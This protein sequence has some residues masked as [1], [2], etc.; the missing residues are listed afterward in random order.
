[1]TTH[2]KWGNPVSAPAG[3]VRG[4]ERA[5]ELF[6]SYQAD[7]VVEIDAML[8]EYPDFALGHA[9]RAGLM[10]TTSD[11][12]FD[13]ELRRS[14]SAAE[15]LA[16]RANERERGH[17][18]AARAWADGEFDRAIELW[19]RVAVAHP[20]DL[21]ATQ[22][23][24][25]GDFYLGYS[26]MLRDRVARV[27][28]HWSR[29]DSGY[30]YLLGMHAFGL[31]ESGDYRR[32]EATGRAAI[33]LD[34]KDAWAVHA[35]AHVLEMQGRAD[36][37]AAFLEDS[38]Q[39]W[40]P[41]CLMSFHN[42][43][44]LTLFNLDRGH[45]AKALQIY[46]DKVAAGGFAQALELVDGSG[47]LWRL[48]ALGHDVGARWQVVA[49]KWRTRID[50]RYYAFNDMCAMMAFVGAGDRD[51]QNRLIAALEQTAAGNDLNAMMARE[52]GLPA[53]RAIAAFGRGAYGEAIDRLLPV[54]GRA[55]RF[56]GSHAQRDAF[57][58]TMVE[59]A[60]RLGDRALADALLAERLALKPDSPLN[61]AWQ[62][63]AR[64]IGAVRAA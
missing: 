9:F 35:V 59:A 50:D 24:H 61:R 13:G 19:G 43:W 49:D 45:V 25:L 11:K 63:R 17:I 10:A 57:S 48:S 20:R 28:T 15:A 38:A 34:G 8:A 2:D 26:H 4:Y 21:A 53:S 58:W 3:A 5:V 39:V 1:M 44:H 18:A 64:R 27:L 33:A 40:A 16:A 41:G 7:P 52:V 37:G 36:E 62:A 6:A 54:R 47:L 22:F 56:G 12:A 30:G 55:N 60:I 42:W 46:D 14:L 31:E 29:Q 32:A 23:A 51:A